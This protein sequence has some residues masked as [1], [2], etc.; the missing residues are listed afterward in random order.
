[1][2]YDRPMPRIDL[3]VVVA[4]V[5][6]KSSPLSYLPFESDDAIVVSLF[7]ACSICSDPS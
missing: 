5:G 4:C 6:S 1:M 3:T 7:D 2:D